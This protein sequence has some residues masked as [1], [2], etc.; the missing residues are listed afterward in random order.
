MPAAACP[1][2]YG[3]GYDDDEVMPAQAGI[4]TPY[5]Q[6]YVRSQTARMHGEGLVL[7]A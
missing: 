6:S 7:R 4:Q 5:V 1:R 2:G 3:G